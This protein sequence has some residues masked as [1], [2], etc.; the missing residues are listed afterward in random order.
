MKYANKPST[1]KD[2]S[3][4]LTFFLDSVWRGRISKLFTRSLS[5]EA[6]SADPSDPQAN[7]SVMWQADGTGTGSDG[8]IMMKIT[9]SGGT[10]KTTTIVDYSA[11]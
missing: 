7:A 8:D 10:T 2:I 9:D 4:E 1:I 6:L 11:V 3:K 5:F